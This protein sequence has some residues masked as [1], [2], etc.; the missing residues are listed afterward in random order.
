[1]K[2]TDPKDKPTRLSQG[3]RQ[4]PKPLH[5]VVPVAGLSYFTTWAIFLILES[6][7]ATGSLWSYQIFF[8]PFVTVSV[9][10]AIGIWRGS[11]FGYLAAVSV[12][13][14]LTVVFFATR[15]G[16]DVITVLT[17]PARN[18]LEF[19]FDLTNVPTFFAVFISAS[20][21]LRKVWRQLN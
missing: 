11:K 12:T 8:L 1:M 17:N 2:Q 20:I 18:S 14:V 4:G 16:H 15:D 10:A 3:L 21:G 5:S 19:L 7:V 9:L 6:I 13:A